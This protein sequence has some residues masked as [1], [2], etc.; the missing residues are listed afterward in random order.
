MLMTS[1]TVHAGASGG[2]V[3]TMDGCIAGI[4]TSNAKHLQSGSTVPNLNFA[5]AADALRALWELAAKPGK[6]C[7]AVLEELDIAD[8][9]LSKLFVLSQA[10]ER[11]NADAEAGL[12]VSQKKQGSARLA[13]LLSQKG[14]T[15]LQQPQTKDKISLSG[16]RSK[17]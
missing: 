9:G 14:L 17:L 13:E 1:A 3:V 10:P 4:A 7:S 5:V 12:A 16:H 15:Q 2:A 11:Q 8:A 6:L